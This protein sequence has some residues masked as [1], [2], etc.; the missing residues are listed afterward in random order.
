MALHDEAVEALADL[1]VGV[2]R[3]SDRYGVGGAAGAKAERIGGDQLCKQALELR[4]GQGVSG[5]VQ[6][7]AGAPTGGA[8]GDP[9]PGW[10]R[11]RIIPSAHA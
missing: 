8:S 5:A 3:L 1:H 4:P 7:L 9:Q 11:L 6:Q 2:F 10:R